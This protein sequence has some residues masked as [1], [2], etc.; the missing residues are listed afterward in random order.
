MKVK[1]YGS[2]EA[3]AKEK[4]VGSSS[5][6]V[7]QKKLEFI[8]KNLS[9]E[10]YLSENIKENEKMQKPNQIKDKVI[11][12]NENSGLEENSMLKSELNLTNNTNNK[13]NDLSNDNNNININ[14]C[15]N[16]IDFDKNIIVLN[17]LNL[18]E[19]N[20]INKDLKN[21]KKNDLASKKGEVINMLINE[22]FNYNK[23]VSNSI[24]TSYEYL[25]DSFLDPFDNFGQINSNNDFPNEIIDKFLERK[26][27]KK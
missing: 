22:K 13:S 12:S 14:N 17:K 11:Q 6:H 8:N 23:E 20:N 26:R 1:D 21:E 24:K 27:N 2:N 18:K 15:I 19:L 16:K 9:N 25:T 7:I 5:P 4:L 10:L 3:I